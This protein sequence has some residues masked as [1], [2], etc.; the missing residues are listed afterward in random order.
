MRWPRAAADEREADYLISTIKGTHRR[1]ISEQS[2]E[3]GKK[4]REEVV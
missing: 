3:I 1:Q 4:K 2:A